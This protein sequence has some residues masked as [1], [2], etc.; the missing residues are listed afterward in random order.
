M[1]I[2]PIPSIEGAGRSWQTQRPCPKLAL[3]NDGS[4][5]IVFIGTGSAFA[6]TRYQTN[7]LIIKGDTH[8]MVDFGMTGPRALKETTGLKVT[9]LDV[10]LPTHSH[11]DHIGGLEQAGL[12]N[13]YVGR[14]FMDKPKLKMVVTEPY[15]EVLWDRSLRGGMEWN[16]EEA[17]THKRLGFTDF[18]DVIRPKWLTQQPREIWTVAIGGRHPAEAIH[19]EMFRTK[20]IP[21]TAP[22]WQASFMSFGLHIDNRVFVSGDTRFDPELIDL[23]ADRSEA[24]FHDVQFF[25]GAV[26]APL[27]DLKTQAAERKKKTCLM[28][29][30][31]NFGSQDISGFMGWAQQGVRYVF[32]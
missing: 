29:Y 1:T 6:E 12:L 13:R 3:K 10:F 11:A 18:F 24:M 25:P 5:E 20:H 7:F 26:H 9:D 30:A 32:D 4:L 15:Q 23:Y 8:V 22:D 21:D 31:D 17:G 19:L 27:P 28:H 2:Q 16:E 14:K